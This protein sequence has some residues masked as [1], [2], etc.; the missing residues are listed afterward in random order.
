M[1]R[2]EVIPAEKA[3]LAWT[4]LQKDLATMVLVESGKEC[5]DVEGEGAPADPPLCLAVVGGTDNEVGIAQ[6]SVKL[7]I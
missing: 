7:L 5:W 2:P 6:P 4:V 3:W 1:L